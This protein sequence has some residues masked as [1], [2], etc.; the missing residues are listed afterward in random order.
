MRRRVQVCDS[1]GLS[2]AEGHV[3][4]YVT[5]EDTTLCGDDDGGG[6]DDE[7]DGCGGGG[8]GC[9]GGGD[10]GGGVDGWL[11]WLWW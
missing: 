3:K 4:L 8:G 9:G 5:S 6:G 2:D 11:C 10:G 7:G 1:Q